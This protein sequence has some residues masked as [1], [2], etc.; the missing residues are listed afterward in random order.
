MGINVVHKVTCNVCEKCRDFPQAIFLCTECFYKWM[1]SKV[2]TIRN[3]AGSG[4]H[5]KIFI[6]WRDGEMVD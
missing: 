3:A 4:L 6:M 1:D 5:D 2:R